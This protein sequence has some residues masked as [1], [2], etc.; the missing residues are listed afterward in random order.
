MRS[1]YAM[2]VE[3]TQANE[4]QDSLYV[5]QFF[6]CGLVYEYQDSAAAN[7]RMIEERMGKDSE[8]NDYDLLKALS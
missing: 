1:V 2:S 6:L 4:T 7:E 3:N 5:N 8:E